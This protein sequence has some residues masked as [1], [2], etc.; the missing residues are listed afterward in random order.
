MIHAAGRRGAALWGVFLP[1]D[2]V[3]T[4][5]AGSLDPGRAFSASRMCAS[6]PS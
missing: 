2:E 5:E 3:V 4:Y 1:D 6:I